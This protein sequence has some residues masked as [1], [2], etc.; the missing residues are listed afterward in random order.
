MA[1]TRVALNRVV[2]EPKGSRPKGK[3][4][5]VLGVSGSIAAYKACEV[6][7]GLVKAGAEV[8]VVATANATRFVAPLTLSVLSRGPVYQDPFDPAAWDMAHLSLA[9]WASKIVIAPATADL[10]ARLAGGRSCGLLESLVL[11]TKSPVVLCPAMDTEMWE[12]L[13]TQGNVARA[14]ELGYE[15]WGPVDGELASG[16]VGMGRLLEPSEIVARILK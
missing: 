6:V 13:A 7:R 14:R 11:S 1:K 12:H 3:H 4:R 9:S 8:K 15:V 16:R 5:I 10:I 2:G